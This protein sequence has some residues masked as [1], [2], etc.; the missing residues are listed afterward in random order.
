MRVVGTVVL[1]VAAL[2]YLRDVKYAMDQRGAAK[3]LA[4]A[5]E[6]GAKAAEEPVA[7]KAAT[8]EV[9]DE[10]YSEFEDD[11]AEDSV[12]R[13]FAEVDEKDD[14]EEG[15]ERELGEEELLGGGVGGAHTLTIRYCTS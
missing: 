8:Q 13:R 11:V 9:E 7:A 3:P 14:D 12:R 6:A 15:E 4:A 5:G 2:V 1:A 10:L